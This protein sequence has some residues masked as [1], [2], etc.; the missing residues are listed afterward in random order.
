MKKSPGLW[1]DAAAGQGTQGYDTFVTF[2]CLK[3]IDAGVADAP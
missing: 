3:T 1:F 2:L